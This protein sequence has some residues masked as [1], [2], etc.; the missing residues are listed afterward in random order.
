M[1]ATEKRQMWF[2]SSP[3]GVPP[4]IREYPIKASQGVYM[5]GAPVYVTQSGTVQLV[6]T[7]AGSD[8]L[9]G[10]MVKGVAAE[11]VAGTLVKVVMITSEQLWAIYCENNGSDTAIAQ[12][13]VGNK[14][15]LV[16]S[17]TSGQ[18]G[19]STMDINDATNVVFIVRDIMSNVE[20][21]KYKTTD[22]PGVAVVSVI[23]TVVEAT[24]AAS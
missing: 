8:A 16:V 1:A 2:V 5:A 20:P 15:G 9:H 22:N 12:S 13:N 19:Y 21:S 10:V 14:Y 6:A 7:S 23:Y 17:A 3:D 4:E 18:I 24:K 11:L